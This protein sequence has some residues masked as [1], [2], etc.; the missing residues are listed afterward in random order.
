[1]EFPAFYKGFGSHLSS[2]AVTGIVFSGAQVLTI[3][4][5]M[6]TGVSLKRIATRI[7]VMYFVS[8][9]DKNSCVESLL[10]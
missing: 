10:S 7:F 1:M 5:G 9:A 4:F 8:A 3:V 2:H 6:G